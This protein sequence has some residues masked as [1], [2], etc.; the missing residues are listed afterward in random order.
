MLLARWRKRHDLGQ[1]TTV[2]DA[3]DGTRQDYTVFHLLSDF[4]TRPAELIE[5][6]RLLVLA[7]LPRRRMRIADSPFT[8]PLFDSETRKLLEYG[9][10]IRPGMIEG[11]TDYERPRPDWMDPLAAELADLAD[12][13]LHWA[14]NLPERDG[15]LV[16]AFEVVLERVERERPGA[17]ALLE[18]ARRAMDQVKDARFQAVSRPV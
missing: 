17:R 13:E 11:F 14:L 12:A 8:I 4:D 5:T 10:F 2:L 6:L 9:G 7:A 1:L 18:Q 15:A 16:R 3:L